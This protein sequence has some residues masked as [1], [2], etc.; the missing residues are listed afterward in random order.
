MTGDS[1]GKGT[2]IKRSPHSEQSQ[3]MFIRSVLST[4]YYPNFTPE[5]IGFQYRGDKSPDQRDRQLPHERTSHQLLSA[6][7]SHPKN[8]VLVPHT[9]LTIGNGSRRTPRSRID[10]EKH[11][12]D[13]IPTEICDALHLYSVDH[14]LSAQGERAF[15]VSLLVGSDSV[16]ASKRIVSELHDQR[17][18]SSR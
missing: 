1:R 12:D 18:V 16:F 9:Q 8:I 6:H 13:C 7:M 11:G 5:N 15:R 3:C 14:P 10:L 2:V 4:N 17:A